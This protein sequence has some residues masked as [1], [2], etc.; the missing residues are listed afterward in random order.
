MADVTDKDRLLDDVMCGQKVRT[1]YRAEVA[2]AIAQA[3][4]EGRRGER[5]AAVQRV[6]HRNVLGVGKGLHVLAAIMDEPVFMP[7]K[8]AAIRAR[9]NA[10]L[11]AADAASED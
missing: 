9:G 2:A 5:E 11:S 8:A 7:E 4:E 1:V 10:A 3:R 6:I